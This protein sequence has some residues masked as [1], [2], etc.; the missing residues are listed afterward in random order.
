MDKERSERSRTTLQRLAETNLAA[1]KEYDPNKV[2]QPFKLKDH[3]IC[4][5]F[6]KVRQ[7][8]VDVYFIPID[9]CL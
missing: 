2:K 1:V 3:F 8:W 9:K 7:K 4:E 6:C 5:E